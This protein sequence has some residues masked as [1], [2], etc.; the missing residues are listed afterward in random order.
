MA[1]TAYAD[2][3]HASC[4]DTRRKA[5]YIAMSGCYTHILWMRSQLTDY[6]FAFT[7]IPL[8]CDNRSA[9]A[10]CCNNVQHSR[11]KHI[12]IRHHFI[13]EQVEKGVVKLYFVMTDYQLAD[14]FTKA[15]PRE[16][17]EFLL[18]R[19]GMKSMTPETLKRIQ[20]GE[21]E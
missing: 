8:Y 5:K 11:S 2:A 9:I 20:E 4:Q 16:R 3:N 1:L 14:I 21:E 10:L 7:R 15:L 6:G 19:L 12:E 17:F 18:P 13:R